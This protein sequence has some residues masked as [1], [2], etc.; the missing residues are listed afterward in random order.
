[1]R[2]KHRFRKSTILS[3]YLNVS[4]I[5]KAEIDIIRYV[6]SETFNNSKELNENYINVIELRSLCPQLIDDILCVG[7]HLTLGDYDKKFKHPAILTKSHSV[8]DLIVRHYHRL[9]GHCGPSYTLSVIRK[10]FWII[11]GLRAVNRIITAFMI[12]LRM[13]TRPILQKMAHL[14]VTRVENVWYPFK[15]VF[16]TIHSEKR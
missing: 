4:E 16:R 7:S 10:R 15:Y 14:P 6:Q 1:M 11:Q 13:A 9:Y 12:C 3:S 2:N 5:Q 8:V